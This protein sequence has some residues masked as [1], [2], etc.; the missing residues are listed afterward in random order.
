MA[1]ETVKTE[2]V[3]LDIRPWSR[4]SHVVRWLTP[5]GPVT[6][7]V[8]GAVRPKSAFLGQYDLNYTC[9]ILYYARAR[10]DLHALRECTPTDLRETLRGNF[11]AL[12]LADYCRH[13]VADL[14][15]T[16]PE[17]AE[18]FA[19]L[20]ATLDRL[21]R[22]G[23]G[24]LVRELLGF[25]LRTLSLAGLSPELEAESG[26]FTL[27]GERQM[28]VSPEIAAAIRNPDGEKNPQILLDAARAIGVFYSFHLDSSPETR[29][30]VLRMVS[31]NEEGTG[32][33][34]G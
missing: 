12:V 1:G 25:E 9:E 16:G 2:A 13:Q 23:N 19:L 11:R 17:A 6:T 26:A 34:D 20:T 22:L 15:P 10:G 21:T 8:K 4:T 14:A 30:T 32:N 7:L 24:G 5:S 28:P 27:R 3:C 33:Q 31:N 18:W 29:R